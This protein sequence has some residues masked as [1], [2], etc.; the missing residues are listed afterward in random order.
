MAT[1]KQRAAAARN[2][3]KAQSAWRAM[4]PRARALAA[5]QGRAR[6]RPGP[7]GGKFYRIE[8]R[9]KRDFVTFR[10]QD[11]GEAGGLERIAGQRSSGRWDTVTWLIEKHCA[12]VTNGKLIIDDAKI[13]T[14]LK[15]LRGPIVHQKGDVFAAKPRRNVSEAEKPTAAQ[16]R[17]RRANI[18]KAQAARKK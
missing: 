2:I 5:P 18:K 13:K 16:R 3:K 8:V 4:T 6:K 10:T 12:H 14:A 17:A 7:G 9:P 1:P 15:Q 11:V